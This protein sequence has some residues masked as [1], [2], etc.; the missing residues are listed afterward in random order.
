[1]QVALGKRPH[2]EIYGT[3]YPT[4]DG[5]CVRDYIHVVDLAQA[6]I[7]ALEA[8]DRGSRVYNLGNGQGFTVREVLEMAR[9]VTGRPIPAVEGPRRPGDPAVLVASA[10][11][12]RRELGW[13]PRYPD[14]RDIVAS[15]W[16]WHRA[17]P[18]GY[19]D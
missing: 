9:E 19:G 5:T 8:L 11:R 10:E 1:M 13:Q 15:A 2:L 6:H 18:D 12:I 17:H 7:L 4:R 16:A 3:D 14:L